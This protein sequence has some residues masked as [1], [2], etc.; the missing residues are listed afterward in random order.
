[1]FT[2]WPG[3][4][5]NVLFSACIKHYALKQ[6][7]Q[8][9][10]G[11]SLDYSNLIDDIRHLQQ[12]FSVGWRNAIAI[13]CL[14]VRAAEFVW[15]LLVLICI[16]YVLTGFCVRSNGSSICELWKKVVVV[17]YFFEY[18]SISL[19]R[20]TSLVCARTGRTFSP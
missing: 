5:L 15:L 14:Y 13:C 6:T 16:G 3:I 8:I 9:D 12:P 11:Y 20:F 10:A 2:R 18:V 19:Q 7:V 4:F 1:M 17:S